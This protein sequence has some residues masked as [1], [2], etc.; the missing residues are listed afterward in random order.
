MT[1]HHAAEGRAPLRRHASGLALNLIACVVIVA[2]VGP[3]AWVAS[4]SFQTETELLT[5]PQ[6]LIPERP[7][8]DNY[9][10]V[11]TGKIPAAYDT[12]GTLRPRVSQEA[13]LI[14]PAMVNSVIVAVA[15]MA[16]NLTLGL[17]AAYAFARL[18][19]RFKTAAF[20]FVLGSRL[21]PA[22]A[23][24][25]PFYVIVQTLGL[26]DTYW[27]MI[28]VYSALTLP[29]TIWFLSVYL[30]NTPREIEEAALVDGCG[31][32]SA[33]RWVVIPMA[34]PGLVA[35][36]AFAFMVSYN[37]FMFARF[38]TQSIQSQTAPVIIASIAGNPDASYT[39]ISVCVTLGLIPPVLLAVLLRRRLT[40]G[41][42]TSVTYR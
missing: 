19:F 18:R 34:M 22:I 36:A 3:V 31:R 42:S 21:I 5:Q 8:L 30:A 29:F 20:N 11:F 12:R 15:V 7:I 16:I 4:A 1:S 2:I 41:L 6:H 23:V 14:G 10:Y 40:A 13:R 38:L 9:E 37:E 28:T 33:L 17:L 25:I 32:L 26:L 35:A 27:S 39:L 24:A